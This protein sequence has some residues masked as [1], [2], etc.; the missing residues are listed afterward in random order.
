MMPEDP[1]ENWII[2]G[3]PRVSEDDEAEFNRLVRDLPVRPESGLSSDGSVIPFHSGP[4]ILQQIRMAVQIVQPRSV[5]EIGFNMGHSAM[6]FLEMGV[7]RVR[8]IDISLRPETEA[9]EN[10]M[11]LRWGCDR[12]FLWTEDSK[13]MLLPIKT[14][15]AKFDMIFIDGAHDIESV[16]QDVQLGKALKIPH[17]LFDD[18]HPHWGPGVIPAIINHNLKVDAVIGSMVLCSDTA[19]RWTKARL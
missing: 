12:F 5:L 18:W 13:N 8:S 1:F 17:F 2:A 15:G 16:D 9:A 10:I 6:L 4:H 3:V 11:L 14:I 7:H 19:V